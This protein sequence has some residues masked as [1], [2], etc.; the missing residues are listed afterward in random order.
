MGAKRGCWSA[1]SAGSW[2]GSESA[3]EISSP[4]SAMVRSHK[5]KSDPQKMA[6]LESIWDEQRKGTR[7]MRLKAKSED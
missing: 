6:L 1:G 3:S 4:G 7:Y 5:G 2:C